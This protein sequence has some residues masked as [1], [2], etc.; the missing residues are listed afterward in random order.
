MD[1]RGPVPAGIDGEAAVLDPP[2]RFSIRPAVL[3]VRIA[4][5][6]PGASPSAV[7]PVGAIAA[8]RALIRIARGRDR[9]PAPRPRTADASGAGGR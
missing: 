7:E 6:H 3:R 2:V 9:R 1:A 5:A 4:A 8:F